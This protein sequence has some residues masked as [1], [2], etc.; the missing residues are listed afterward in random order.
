MEIR[1][2]FFGR[3]RKLFTRKSVRLNQK[4]LLLLSLLSLSFNRTRNGFR[5]MVTSKQHR[6]GVKTKRVLLFSSGHAQSRLKFR[7]DFLSSR[8]YFCHDG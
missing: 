4:R 1:K 7:L 2:Y 3:A 6:N 8:R 5:R